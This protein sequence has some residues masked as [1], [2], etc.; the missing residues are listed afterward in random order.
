MKSSPSGSITCCEERNQGGSSDPNWEKKQWSVKELRTA[1][2]K[3][4][5][6]SCCLH[7]K[8]ISARDWEGVGQV[9]LWLLVFVLVLGN[10]LL[11]CQ[12]QLGFFF[13]LF[14]FSVLLLGFY[15][16]CFSV[17]FKLTLLEEIQSSCHFR[18]KTSERWFRLHTGNILPGSLADW[19]ERSCSATPLASLPLCGLSANCKL[20]DTMTNKL[21]LF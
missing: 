5:R 21:G 3:H 17:L 11:S 9:V 1:L 19:H 18:R 16:I 20:K 7:R 15:I 4:R 12:T 6:K 13:H 14:F 8:A 10:H 2:L